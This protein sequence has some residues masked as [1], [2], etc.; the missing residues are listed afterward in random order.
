MLIYVSFATFKNKFLAQV[1]VKN[2]ADG[3]QR[4]LFLDKVYDHVPSLPYFYGISL[5]PVVPIC[6]VLQSKLAEWF[7]GI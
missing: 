7:A 4:S 1:T 3:E 2:M 5:H 6:I